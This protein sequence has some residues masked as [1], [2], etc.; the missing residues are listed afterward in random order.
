MARVYVTREIPGAAVAMLRKAGHSVDVYPGD[1]PVP[2]AT[3]LRKVKGVNAILSLLTDRIDDKVLAAAG[4]ELKIVA[5]YAVGYDNLDLEALKKRGVKAA[6]TPGVLNDAVAEHTFALLLA[7]AKRIPES[8]RFVRAG[9]YAGWKPKLLLGSLLEGKTLG[10]IGVGRIG[11]GVVHRASC[12]GMDI[13]YHDIRR[14][15]ALERRYKAK[16]ATKA[17]LLKR[18]DFVSLHVPLLKSTY[19]LIGAKELRN[20]KRT[21][22]LVNTARGPV[23]DEKA[24]VA[25][26]R[27]KVIAGAA[28]DVFED[29][30][31]LAPGLARLENAILTPHTAS[32]A[33]ETREEMSRLA[34]DAILKALA[35]KRPKNLIPGT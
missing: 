10:I 2:R 23:V 12:M 19:H 17:S 3:L 20:M 7:A 13:L 28:L 16:F 27:K 8:D 4:P 30:P 15:R 24:L 31:R 29:E 34:A 14:D 9:K 18:S 26:L 22:I 32:A 25:A 11:T 35:G 5:N 1:R 6:N 21:A 33:I